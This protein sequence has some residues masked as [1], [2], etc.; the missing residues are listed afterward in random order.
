MADW[1]AEL[2]K[3]NVAI[4]KH[5]EDQQRKDPV[6]QSMLG[7]KH[8]ITQVIKEQADEKIADD[9]QLPIAGE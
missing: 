9:N 8:I 4:S 2:E 6:L 5:I 1:K 3:L 7:Q